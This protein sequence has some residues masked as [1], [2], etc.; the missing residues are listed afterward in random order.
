MKGKHKSS[1]SGMIK[2]A[3]L[4]T[5]H[6]YLSFRSCGSVARASGQQIHMMMMMMMM[7]V[8]IVRVC[9]IRSPLSR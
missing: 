8:N 3:V 7:F 9:K 2:L 6:T 1:L 4:I 5:G